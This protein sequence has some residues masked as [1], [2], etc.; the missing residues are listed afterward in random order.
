MHPATS[1]Y[2]L[3]AM[4]SME[5]PF[6]DRYTCFPHL[7]YGHERVPQLTTARWK[8][9]GIQFSVDILVLSW[10]VILHAFTGELHPVF[11]LDGEAVRA[12]CSA[13]TFSKIHADTLLPE[14][15]KYTGIFTFDARTTIHFKCGIIT[16]S[17]SS[18]RCPGMVAPWQLHT[19]PRNEADVSY[20]LSAPAR[21]I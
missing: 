21:N 2:Q 4:D 16:D 1:C 11:S 12:D 3:I 17:E 9:D 18:P 20:Q 10:A 15:G 5:T 14:G 6:A 7:D 13:R 8:A 19:I